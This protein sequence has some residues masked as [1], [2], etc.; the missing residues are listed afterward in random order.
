MNGKQL[1]SFSHCQD[2]TQ[3]DTRTFTENF[4]KWLIFF[5]LTHC[6]AVKVSKSDQIIM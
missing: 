5:F 1:R 4:K 3:N 6:K 2:W